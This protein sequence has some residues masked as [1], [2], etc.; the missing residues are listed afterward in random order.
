MGMWIGIGL[1]VESCV[2]VVVLCIIFSITGFLLEA[3]FIH[4]LAGKLDCLFY[5]ILNDRWEVVDR[6]DIIKALCYL[7]FI[8]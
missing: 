8:D 5:S 1:A 3:K 4:I 2:W 7:S 6:P